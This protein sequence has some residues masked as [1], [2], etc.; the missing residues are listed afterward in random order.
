ML[1]NDGF[2][3]GEIDAEGLVV[4]DITFD[5]LD[6]R[7][8]LTKPLIRF[9]GCAT[10]LVSFQRPNGWNVPFDDELSQCQLFLPVWFPTSR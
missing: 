9:R 8:K 6:I 4:S 2:I 5:P 3:F 7:A 10:K 1:L